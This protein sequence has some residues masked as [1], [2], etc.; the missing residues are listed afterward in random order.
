M[1]ATWFPARYLV[2]EGGFLQKP[3][4]YKL[5]PLIAGKLHCAGATIG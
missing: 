2:T 5:R 4:E 3:D 1:L